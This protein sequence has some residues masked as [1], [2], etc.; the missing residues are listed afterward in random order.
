LLSS[1]FI[2]DTT[3]QILSKSAEFYKR[4]DE[5]ILAYLFLTYK[6]H[7]SKPQK[8]KKLAQAKTDIQHQTKL[9]NPWCSRLSTQTQ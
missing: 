4:Y 1:K 5:N 9:Q 2:H 6:K 8:H 7:A 3:H